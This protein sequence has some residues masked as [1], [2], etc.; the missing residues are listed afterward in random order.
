MRI[1]E[2]TP[3]PA[4]VAV[5]YS[6]VKTEIARFTR[7]CQSLS[8][9]INNPL[10]EIRRTHLSHDKNLVMYLCI[11]EGDRPKNTYSE[12]NAEIILPRNDWCN[13]I[14]FIKFHLIL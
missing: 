8:L 4:Q 3:G 10:N 13:K 12:R 5:I 14:S 9:A 6:S 7:S 1:S 2:K 11:V